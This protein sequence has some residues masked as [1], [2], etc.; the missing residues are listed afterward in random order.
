MR[1]APDSTAER[2]I[3]QV[4]LGVPTSTRPIYFTGMTV[5]QQRPGWHTL[6][7]PPLDAWEELLQWLTPPQRERFET[8]E[9]YRM[10]ESQISRRFAALLE[11]RE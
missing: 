2:A 6:D 11:R 9:F 3:A 4:T 7:V 8:A 10:L 1:L 5:R